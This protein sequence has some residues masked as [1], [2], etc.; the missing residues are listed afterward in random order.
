MPRVIYSIATDG[1]IYKSLAKIIPKFK[2]PVAAT[3][4][5]GLTTGILATIFDLGQLV[6]LTSIGMYKI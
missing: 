6:E 3:I 1:L 5:S 2:T 4:V